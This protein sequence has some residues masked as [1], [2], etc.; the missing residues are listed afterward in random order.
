MYVDIAD[1]NMVEISKIELVVATESPKV[2]F[3]MGIEDHDCV[4]PMVTKD[5]YAKKIKVVFPKLRKI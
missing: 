5:Q 1:V 3:E 2:D 4:D